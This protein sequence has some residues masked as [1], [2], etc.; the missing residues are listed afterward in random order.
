VKRTLKRGSKAL[1]IVKREPYATVDW[2]RS[3]HLGGGLFLVSRVF[4]AAGRGSRG[5]LRVHVGRS[6][7]SIGSG[8][9]K[10]EGSRCFGGLA[11]W[12]LTGFFCDVDPDRGHKGKGVGRS[13][14]SIRASGWS[15]QGGG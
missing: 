13:R 8:W 15:R 11:L 1:E 3:A 4:M 10:S 14:G 12:G 2:G 6:R 9:Q 7:I 5:F